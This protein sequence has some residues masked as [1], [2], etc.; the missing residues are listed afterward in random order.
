M[1]KNLVNFDTWGGGGQYQYLWKKKKGY[2]PQKLPN[3][4]PNDAPIF[5]LFWDRIFNVISS[6]IIF[7]FH[8]EVLKCIKYNNYFFKPIYK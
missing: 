7:V 6:I 4:V 5:G 2:F 8:V 3:I 1:I